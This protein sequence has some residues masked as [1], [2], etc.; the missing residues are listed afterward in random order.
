MFLLL[1]TE[2]VACSS[3]YSVPHPTNQFHNRRRQN[4]AWPFTDPTVLPSTRE[5]SEKSF[6]SGPWD[7]VKTLVGWA[8]ES[9]SP[10]MHNLDRRKVKNGHG[11]SGSYNVPDPVRSTPEGS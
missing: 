6:L 10:W 4:K 8:A 9:N 5:E 7:K 1:H 3:H 11:Q 2:L